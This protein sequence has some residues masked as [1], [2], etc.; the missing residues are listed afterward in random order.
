MSK[1][2]N[3]GLN[4]MKSILVAILLM[5]CE[6]DPVNNRTYNNLGEDLIEKEVSTQVNLKSSSLFDLIDYGKKLA[7]QLSQQTEFGFGTNVNKDWFII[8]SIFSSTIDSLPSQCVFFND[9][10][11]FTY[12]IHRTKLN[13]NSFGFIWPV[14]TSVNLQNLKF[15]NTFCIVDL[16][17][18]ITCVIN[19]ENGVMQSNKI[20]GVSKI[21][22]LDSL[23]NIECMVYGEPIRPHFFFKKEKSNFYSY[24]ENI[25]GEIFPEEMDIV[26]F[27]NICMGKN[28]SHLIKYYETPKSYSPELPFHKF[29]EFR[30]M[31]EIRE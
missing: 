27:R 26:E 4:M 20:E 17:A 10:T 3:L 5:S 11:T 12:I 1:C 2:K 22:I 6:E 7:V 23:L 18:K 21:K 30:K 29:Y 16:N 28:E 19:F 15:L 8:D 14:E 9:D 25:N 13:G 31:I 24:G